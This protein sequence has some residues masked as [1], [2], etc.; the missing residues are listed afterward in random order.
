VVG[1]VFDTP[2]VF[3]SIELISDDPANMVKN[4]S[5]QYS[6]DVIT[7][8]TEFNNATWTTVLTKTGETGWTNG[9]S[10]NYTI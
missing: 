8:E 5:I 1:K 6:D 9:E 10:R 2:I 7:N 3:D 4:I